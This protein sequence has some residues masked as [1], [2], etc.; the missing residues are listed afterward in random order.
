MTIPVRARPASACRPLA[1]PQSAHAAASAPLVAVCAGSP[2]VSELRA[3]AV[4]VHFLKERGG[5]DYLYGLLHDRVPHSGEN[6]SRWVWYDNCRTLE[7]ASQRVR[8]WCQEH[9]GGKPCSNALDP[10]F[11]SK[12]VRAEDEKKQAPKQARKRLFLKGAAAG[13]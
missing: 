6:C 9:C 10:S 2:R 12:P 13:E 1:K 5:L 4:S 11:V 3:C 7:G 8:K